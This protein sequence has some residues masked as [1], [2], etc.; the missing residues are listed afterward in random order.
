MLRTEAP[1]TLGK[2]IDFARQGLDGILNVMPFTCMP[3]A[4]V[5]GLAGRIRADNGHIPWLD[6][7]FD[8]L[9]ETNQQTRLEAFLH[10]AGQFRHRRSDGWGRL[11]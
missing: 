5:A 1:L 2:A 3:G 11:K 6:V 9:G 4:V 10:Q 7:S 8:G